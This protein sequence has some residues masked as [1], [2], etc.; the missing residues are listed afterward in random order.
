MLTKNLN[1]RPLLRPW[2]KD[3]LCLTLALGVFTASAIGLFFTIEVLYH[4]CF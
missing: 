4:A 2:L 3:A 1:K